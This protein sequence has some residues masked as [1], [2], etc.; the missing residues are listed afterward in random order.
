MPR[1][2]RS[3]LSYPPGRS[4]GWKSPKGGSRTAPTPCFLMDL[5]AL[6][7][8]ANAQPQ[9][10]TAALKPFLCLSG[11]EIQCWGRSSTLYYTQK[12]AVLRSQAICSCCFLLSMLFFFPN[13]LS[14]KSQNASLLSSEVTL[15]FTLYCHFYARHCRKT[16]P[17]GLTERNIASC[18]SSFAAPYFQRMLCCAQ[19]GRGTPRFPAGR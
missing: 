14:R 10:D 4:S 2:G 3:E 6:G 12:I 13:K 16:L 5:P 15:P 9:G 19:T 17:S 11:N 1:G 8:R 18:L 7:V